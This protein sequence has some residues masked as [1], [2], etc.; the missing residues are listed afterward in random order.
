MTPFSWIAAPGFLRTNA[1][2]N[3]EYGTNNLEDCQTAEKTAGPSPHTGDHALAPVAT[4]TATRG[5]PSDRHDARVADCLR[6]GGHFECQLVDRHGVPLLPKP[7]ERWRTGLGV[8]ERTLGDV[9]RRER[10]GRS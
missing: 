7:P 5:P 9:R 10:F 4:R 6:P 2:A 8:K 3:G 1:N